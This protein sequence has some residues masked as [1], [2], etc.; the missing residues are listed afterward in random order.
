MNIES[1][2]RKRFWW[3][4]GVAIVTLILVGTLLWTTVVL[5]PQAKG[6]GIELTIAQSPSG[7]ASWAGHYEDLRELCS[8]SDLVVVGEA[9][10]YT[11]LKPSSWSHSMELY[12][13]TTAFKVETTLKGPVLIEI[14]L[15]SS[16]RNVPG[17]GW[18]EFMAESPPLH[19]GERWVLFLQWSKE[20]GRYIEFGPWALY[21]IIDDRV[22]SM[23][24]VL[25]DEN[26]YPGGQLDFNGISP[27]DFVQQINDTLNSPTMVLAQMGLPF[28]GYRNHAGVYQDV[29]ITFWTGADVSGNLAFKVT[30]LDAGGLPVNEA[31]TFTLKPEEI[32]VEPFTEYR[33]TMRFGTEGNLAPGIYEVRVDYS[34]AGYAGAQSFRL[35]IEPIE[36]TEVPF[37]MS[38]MDSTS[39]P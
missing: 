17:E 28:R 13:L 15:T 27:S 24:R 29:D 5:P 18:V 34:V 32:D 3:G 23:D 4:L 19:P 2:R 33:T 31:L 14:G 6:K 35:W 38:A 12:D 36:R 16:I 7:M 37:M 30:L 39:S 20:L 8:L 10:R 9:D 1:S 11:E 25:N 21:K 22:Y 26:S